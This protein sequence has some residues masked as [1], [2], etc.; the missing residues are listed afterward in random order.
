MAYPL[1]SPL[2]HIPRL[3]SDSYRVI[4]LLLINPLVLNF[5]IG[6]NT[7]SFMNQ[8]IPLTHDEQ[9][10]QLYALLGQPARLKLV[11][12]IG[13][14]EACVCHLR[15]ALKY[16]QAYISQ[17]LMLLRQGNILST[18]RIGRHIY[19]RLTTPALLQQI[20]QTAAIFNVLLEEVHLSSTPGCEY[21]PHFQNTTIKTEE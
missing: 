7:F 8:L 3:L 11:L 13:D 9:L 4:I 6:Y 10:A 17:Q 15:Q 2:N 12:A 16:R 18:R 20:R 1:C 19:Y 14:G 5:S 21:K